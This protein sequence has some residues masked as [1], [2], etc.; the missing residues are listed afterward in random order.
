MLMNNTL[1]DYE[2]IG[3]LGGGSQ[4]TVWRAI[5][6]NDKKEVAIKE[7]FYAQADSHQRSLL[8]RE[9]NLLKSFNNSHIIRYYDRIV[10]K[11]NKI[12]YLV[13]EFCAG[14]DLANFIRQTRAHRSHIEESQ[15]W[16]TLSE[17]ALA[18]KDCHNNT[19]VIL[20][21]DIKPENIFID[22]KGH[23]KLGDFGIARPL[24]SNHHMT[25]VGTVP[26]MSP[27]L[28]FGKQYDEKC[29]IWAL[30]CVIY[31]M[32][33]LR[34]PFDAI[35]EKDFDAKIASPHPAKIPTNY[36][37][38]LW[39][40][41]EQM[42]QKDPSL[43]PSINDILQWRVVKNTICLQ[44]LNYERSL[45]HLKMDRLKKK[46]RELLKADIKIREIAKHISY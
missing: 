19:P 16:L 11:E 46:E 7:I 40:C 37:N 33:M 8:V 42:L 15:I 4:G 22:N 38:S 17:M 1:K 25:R 6:K 28:K 27:E 23:I 2:L 45:I 13:M 34:L 44:Q 43:R 12:V 30:G 26:Y 36:S 5:R 39:S 18:L 32:A 24:D 3:R 14:G 20:H 31:Q 9:I 29:D 35:N 21:R 41:I 10:D